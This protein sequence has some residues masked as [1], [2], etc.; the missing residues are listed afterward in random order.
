M[1][2]TVVVFLLAQCAMQ[3]NNKQKL[4]GSS[5]RLAELP[6]SCKESKKSRKGSRKA[7]RASKDRQPEPPAPHTS[8]EH[9][10]ASAAGTADN[11]KSE[12]Q[13]SQ[14][15]AP[16]LPAET[17]ASVVSGSEQAQQPEAPASSP[18]SGETEDATT[19]QRKDEKYDSNGIPWFLAPRGSEKA[20]GYWIKSKKEETQQSEHTGS[21]LPTKLPAETE[22]SVV[23]GSEQT[24][25]PE[26]PASSPSSGETEDTTTPQREDEKYDS[27]GIPWFFAPRGSEKGWGYWIKSKKEETQ[28][29]E[30][31]GSDLPTE[32]AEGDGHREE[33]PPPSTTPQPDHPANPLPT[34]AS[35]TRLD[36]ET[37][38][39]GGKEQPQLPVP[40]LGTEAAKDEES[41]GA[42][43]GVQEQYVGPAAPGQPALQTTSHALEPSEQGTPVLPVQ[44]PA[45]SSSAVGW[46]STSAPA[47]V[48]CKD[49][50]LG[51]QRLL[52]QRFK[53]QPPAPSSSAVGLESGGV[54]AGVQGDAGPAAPGQPALQTTS[55]TWPPGMVGTWVMAVQP[56]APSSSAVG[57]ESGGVPWPPSMAGAWVMPGQQPAPSSSA[58]GWDST[59]APAGVQG[60]GAGSAT[61]GQP[62]LQMTSTA[63][64]AG[65]QV[66]PVLPVQPPAPANAAF[67]LE[68]GGVPAG[69]QEQ[70][71]GPAPPDQ[72]ALQT[73]ST[74]WPPAKQRTPVVR[75]QPSSPSS[76]ADGLKSGGAPAG[77]QE[78]DAGPAAPVQPRLEASPV[79]QEPDA[80]G[81]SEA[82]VPAEAPVSSSSA[83]GLES[84]KAGT[85]EEKKHGAAK[86]SP[87]VASFP[88]RTETSS[89]M[90]KVKQAAASV[91]RALGMTG[92]SSASDT[93]PYNF[94]LIT[95]QQA[96]QDMMNLMIFIQSFK[97]E[98]TAGKSGQFRTRFG[99]V[100]FTFDVDY[101]ILRATAVNIEN[102]MVDLA[103]LFENGD[104]RNGLD[105]LL[106]ITTQRGRNVVGCIEIKIVAQRTS[107]L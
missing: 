44:P 29:S 75:E 27:N 73:T 72:P 40:V 86:A 36:L 59:G 7:G 70:Y 21:D 24:Q 54:P 39:T 104:T 45:P 17:E 5:R 85:S 14:P 107:T 61:P 56:P 47:G 38:S 30:H 11:T 4:N 48:L 57:W 64:S 105:R 26:A 9:A 49:R 81:T 55:I 58:I 91:G 63:W 32:N 42:P 103:A 6:A 37:S 51:Q 69:V 93:C 77:V 96:R 74:A 19:T 84:G 98:T 92:Q 97:D 41:A 50:V 22:A 82:E 8:P 66:A 89:L 20:W 10:D 25:Q 106:E 18:S 13:P 83:D 62:A 90:T 33:T 102:F 65:T 31:T 60:Q 87:T 12:P 23:S 88:A 15:P 67:G 68:S 99:C 43:A 95:D 46:E 3:L 76:S 2:A 79:A 1:A 16:K 101:K 52:S 53:R 35:E 71:A 100:T 28:Q 94:P 78:Q 34:D 80:Q